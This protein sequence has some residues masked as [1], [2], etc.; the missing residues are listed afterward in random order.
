MC[1]ELESFWGFLKGLL[2]LKKKGK[3]NQQR[4]FR[5]NLLINP[6]QLKWYNISFLIGHL[7]LSE[8]WE[9]FR[10]MG[11]KHSFT[12]RIETPPESRSNPSPEYREIHFLGHIWILRLMYRQ[13]LRRFLGFGLKPRACSKGCTR[14][15]HL[16]F[17]RIGCLWSFFCCV[18]CFF[19]YREQGFLK[20]TM[21]WTSE[22]NGG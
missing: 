8:P 4:C 19:W 17:F 20:Q 13:P 10:W 14:G 22:D 15:H 18:W 9:I 6:I 16:S 11:G 21:S 7:L 5:W 12:L 3:Q 2:P 1:H